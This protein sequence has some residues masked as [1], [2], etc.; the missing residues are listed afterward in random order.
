MYN[1][2]FI[3]NDSWSIRTQTNT[4]SNTYTNTGKSYLKRQ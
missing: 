1:I 3:L 4:D 2:N